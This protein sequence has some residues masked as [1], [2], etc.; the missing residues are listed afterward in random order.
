MTKFN[1]SKTP[2]GS[3]QILDK[4]DQDI[5]PWEQA[6]IDILKL[7]TDSAV[8]K[9]MEDGTIKHGAIGETEDFVALISVGWLKERVRKIHRIAEL[10]VE[11]LELLS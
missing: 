2:S 3:S 1:D 7:L 5:S 9:M 11:E 4:P 8:G 6:T 10:K